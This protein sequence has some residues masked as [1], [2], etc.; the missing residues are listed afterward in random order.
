MKRIA[1]TGANGLVGSR[2][3][4]LLSTKYEFVP[5]PHS[6]VDITDR[7]S[8]AS[9]LRGIEYDAFLH[10]AA[11]T[12]VDGA[13]TEYEKAMGL[14]VDGTRHV[15]EATK[16]KGVPFI[17]FSTDF[18]FDGDHPPYNE[19]SKPNPISAY[20][21]TKRMA[22]QAV[23]GEALVIRISYPYRASFEPKKD[24]VRT[25]KG[26]LE[27]GKEL[28]M[29]TDSTM[30]P[31]FIDDIAPALDSLLEHYS[32]GLVHVV[33]GSAI[34]PFESGKLI[35]RSFGLDEDLVQ[36]IT[37]ADFF[38]NRAQRPRYS[39][40][41]STRNPVAMKDYEEGLAEMIRQIG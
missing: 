5:V 18:V 34:S 7:E 20:G 27:Q 23:E 22:E 19:E 17:L 1:L 25:I 41:R 40:I 30:T 14:N 36:P 32:P 9:Y 38:A 10:L 31:T 16:N 33:G 3:V 4:E 28:K 35:A 13:E 2:L 37:Y 11:Y 8:T 21:S 24:F 39:D 12:N 26:L 15:F 29:V 6:A